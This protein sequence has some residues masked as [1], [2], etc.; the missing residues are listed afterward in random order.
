MKRLLGCLI[1]VALLGTAG[2]RG[3][4]PTP[5]NSELFSGIGTIETGL[6][7]I[8]GLPFTRPVPYGVMSK[9]QLRRYLEKRLH[10][11]SKPADFR[12]EELV[13]KLLGL[14]PGDFDLR[15]NT[16]DL[17]T[18]QAAAFY[19]YN[20]KKLFILAGSGKDAEEQ[21]ALVHE[22]AHA[23]A[24]QHYPLA[25]FINEGLRSDDASTARQAVM[26]GQASWLMTAYVSK[27]GGGPADVPEGTLDLMTTELASTATDYPVLSNAPAYIRESLV[28]PYT[29][30]MKFQDAVYRKLGRESF[31]EVFLH[32]PLSTQQIMH[33]D[34]YFTHVLPRIPDAPRIPEARQFRKLADGTLGEL[35]YRIL[36]SEYTGKEEGEQMA[37]HFAGGTYE[38]LELKR[39]RHPV[40]AFASTWDSAESAR[41]F[42]TQY[43]RV[44]EGKWKTLAIETATAWTLEGHGDAGYFRVWID[45]VTVNHLE[46]WAS[47]LH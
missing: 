22:L 36:L 41:Q 35:D 20:K 47:P 27:L 8:T 21:V 23:M 17:L 4:A 2:E 6:S 28:F 5:P 38:L 37:S 44:L 9:D 39:G 34:R 30:G 45:G 18:E 43:R 19:D 13:L 26:E 33:P 40:L 3:S 25:K 11:T 1:A 14:V 12:A 7:D 16:I 24:D 46:G 15:Q 42:L 31:S 32:P 10:Q 29:A